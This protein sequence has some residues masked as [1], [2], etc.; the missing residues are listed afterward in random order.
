MDLL[1]DLREEAGNQKAACG[2]GVLAAE[3]RI[4][5]SVLLARLSSQ[6]EQT[7]MQTTRR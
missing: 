4:A 5:P 6:I 1:D 3:S 2:K 7:G